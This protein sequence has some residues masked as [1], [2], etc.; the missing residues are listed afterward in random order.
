MGVLVLLAA[1]MLL[2][3]AALPGRAVAGTYTFA[4]VADTYSKSTEPSSSFGTSVRTSTQS[5]SQLRRAYLRFDVRIPSGEVV[6]GA[7]LRL[8]TLTPGPREGVQ[9]RGVSDTRWGETTLTWGNQPAVSSTVSS[10]QVSYSSDTY[11]SWD[12]TPLITGAGP[13]SMGLTTSTTDW[14]GFATREEVASKRPQLVVR[15]AASAPEPTPTTTPS[16]T[17]TATPTATHTPAPSPA[18]E[19]PPSGALH[20]TPTQAFVDGTGREI[21]LHGFNVTPIWSDKPGQTW[22]QSRYEQIRAKGFNAVRYVLKWS[23]F[24]PAAGSYNQ[25][26]LLTLD[27]AIARAKAA[28]LYVIL[29]CIHLFGPGGMNYVPAWARSGDSVS[30]VQSYASPYLKTLASRYRNEPTVA[31]YD[32]VNEPYRWPIDQ[33]AVLRMYDSLIR[34]VR[35]VDPHKI[36][37]VEPTYGDTSIAGSLADFSNLT[38][39]SNVVWTIHDYFAGGD[40]DGY[41]AD[42]SKA[43]NYVFGGTGGYPTPNL[44]Q[45]ENH[46]SIH[47]SKTRLAGIP[48]W[49]GEYGI[50]DGTANHDQWIKDKGGLFSKYGLGR[51]WWEYRTSGPM[52]AT[53]STGTWKPWVNLI[54]PGTAPPADTTAPAA[55]TGVNATAGDGQ[56]TLKWSANS[57]SDLAGYR[58]YR[59]YA[60][61]TWPTSPTATTATTTWTDSAAR[62]GTAYTYRVTARDATG[63]ESQPS[64]SATATPQAPTP[65]PTGDPVIAAAGDIAAPQTSAGST[66]GGQWLT[67]DLL[68]QIKPDAVLTLGD[69]VYDYGY[70]SS[71]EKYYTPN[72]GRFKGV[73]RA[74]NGGSHDF[75]GGG[76]YYTYF[77]GQAGPSP[78]S[79]YSYDVGSWHLIAIN[80]YCSDAHVGGCGVGSKWHTWLKNDLATHANACTLVYWHQPYWTSGSNHAPYT[81]V[82]AYMDLLYQYG[83]DVLLQ[84]HNHQYERFAPMTPS[85]A[86]DDVRGIQSFVVGTGG[87]SFY[88]FNSTPAP[89]SL[90]R[91]NNTF[92]VLKMT[93]RPASWDWQFVPISGKTFTDSGTRSCH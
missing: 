76:E 80:N 70:L 14:I 18:P 36:I 60:D 21:A 92:G 4:A 56:V 93:L 45:L 31:G 37:L 1:T 25:T 27:T 77:G 13:V 71:F 32:L 55:P 38:V 20:S 30:T 83:V 90:A 74:I 48:M 46:L 87:R 22:D 86:R 7:A 28:G 57:E 8:F 65:P 79:S 51:S 82:R 41:N 16:P 44:Q 73:T 2:A 69:H 6:S 39:K 84:A 40:E 78:Y 11:V 24:E 62:N 3:A 75:Y 33:N 10:S 53:D 72:W 42:G 15:T 29:D 47:L 26:S 59:R 35:T 89:N 88:G 64:S 54:A 19:P 61:G 12:A 67:D 50:G 52:S 17:P 34:Q 63:N 81:G 68:D 9:L 58:V 43:G 66:S 91:N 49:I 5:G 85:G 23:D